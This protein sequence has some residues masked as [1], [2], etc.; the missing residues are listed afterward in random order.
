MNKLYDLITFH[1]NTTPALNE[2]NLNAMSEA[3]NNIDDRVVQIAGD[4]LEKAH[5]IMELSE[6]P[7]YIGSNGN[8]YIWD[9]DEGEYTDSGIDAS[10]T[11]EIADVTALAPDATPYVT[12][13]GTNT[14]PIF[15]LFIPRGQTG[16][17]GAQGAQGIQ[18]EKGDKGDKGDTGDTGQTGTTPNISV[19]ASVDANTGTPSVTVTKTG[20]AE[21]PNYALAFSNLKGEQGIQGA[22]GDTG[23]TGATGNGIASIA[24]TGT[25]G[26]VDTYTI[27]FTDGTTTTFTVTNGQDGQGSGDMLKSVYDTDNDGK[28]DAAEDADTVNGHTVGVDVPSDAVFT[29]TTYSAG[30]GISISANEI[31]NSGVRSVSVPFNGTAT[32]TSYRSQTL[33][34]NTGGSTSYS[35]INASRYMEISNT[36]ATT[37]TFTNSIIT[38]S[39]AIEVYTDT[40]GDNPSNVTVSSS[41]CTVTFDE[42]KTRT[43]RIYIK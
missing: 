7:P 4:V 11:V 18:G 19:T 40:Y 28:V 38:T 32:A 30:A 3:I 22:Q 8:W 2:D 24:K 42:A 10:I 9:T 26:L 20:T 41:T 34:K 29:D 16:A 21:S 25:S 5:S 36:S 6:N 12:N 39:S 13:T 15:H 27:T 35:D 37:Y 23:A 43:V 17:Q 1:N 33:S 14:D 31:S